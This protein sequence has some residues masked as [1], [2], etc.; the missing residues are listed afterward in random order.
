[1]YTFVMFLFNFV[2]ES[3]APATSYRRT[4]LTA[5]LGLLF[6]HLF[7]WLIRRLYLRPPVKAQNWWL[8]AML[9]GNLL[10]FF[11]FTNALVVEWLGLSD[12]FQ[13][14]NLGT[15]ALANLYFDSPLLLLWVLVY[16]IWHF[17]SLENQSPPHVQRGARGNDHIVPAKS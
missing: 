10:F 7:R 1:M 8:L 2:A 6:T 14:V 17:A 9:F 5:L 13:R 3:P 12:R 11:T 15:R 4:A 16:Y